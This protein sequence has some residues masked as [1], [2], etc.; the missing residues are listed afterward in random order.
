M[1]RLLRVLTLAGLVLATLT[2]FYWSAE[3]SKRGRHLTLEE[4]SKTWIGLS[5]N[6]L[7]SIRVRLAVDGSGEG[8]YRFLNEPPHLF[9]IQRWE[10]SSGKIEIDPATIQE[11][12]SWLGPISGTV[13]GRTMTLEREG[14]DWT[15]TFYL[16]GEEELLEE[17][18]ALKE[19][20][21]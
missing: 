12:S 10:Y 9:E 4:V 18:R 5:S 1:L 13:L 8:A 7:Y 19:S 11:S 3:G 21:Q 6:E 15:L 2:L 20:M 14:D 16:R 17:W